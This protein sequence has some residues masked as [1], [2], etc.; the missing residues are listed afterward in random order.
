MADPARRR[1]RVLLVDDDPDVLRVLTRGL[2]ARGFEVLGASSVE[3]ALELFEE[4]GADAVVSDLVMAGRAG[5]GLLRE[6]RRTAPG[7]PT[8]AISGGGAIE[9]SFY[10]E[11][12]DATGADGVLQKPFEPSELARILEELLEEESDGPPGVAP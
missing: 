3:E 1:H 6:V 12:A 4:Q 7:T 8:V 11:A 9:A 2:E 5:L 10:L